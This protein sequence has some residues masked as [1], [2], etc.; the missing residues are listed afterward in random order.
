[1]TQKV[2][3]LSDTSML[4][5]FVANGVPPAKLISIW[6]FCDGKKTVCGARADKNTT[7]TQQ[8]VFAACTAGIAVHAILLAFGSIFVLCMLGE[9]IFFFRTKIAR[10]IIR[11]Y[12][13]AKKIGADSAEGLAKLSVQ[14]KLEAVVSD[15]DIVF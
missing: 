12:K 3:S 1:M 4:S 8:I 15:T 7:V 14:N 2:S 6:T 10:K 13:T 9:L 5:L 11:T